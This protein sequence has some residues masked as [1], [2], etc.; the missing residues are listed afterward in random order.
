[1]KMKLLN[2]QITFT[3]LYCSTGKNEQCT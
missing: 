1:M 3:K 2:K